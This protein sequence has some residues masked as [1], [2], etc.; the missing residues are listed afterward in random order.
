VAD[1]RL[2]DA[3]KA[4]REFA[5]KAQAQLDK[6]PAGRS[7]FQTGRLDNFMT[8]HEPFRAANNNIADNMRAIVEDGS[9]SEAAKAQLLANL[10]G[11]AAKAGAA[12]AASAAGA[13]G[14]RALNAVDPEDPTPPPPNAPGAPPQPPEPYHPSQGDMY[15]A[16]YGSLF[17]HSLG[18][19]GG[20]SVF[21]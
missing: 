7:V 15:S 20:R 17:G 21:G 8:N 18:D 5:E 9:L 3:R 13:L 6:P 12:A 16:N 1:T 2:A 19:G 11:N 10:R 14:V 4:S